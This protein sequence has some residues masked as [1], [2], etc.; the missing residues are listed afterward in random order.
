MKNELVHNIEGKTAVKIAQSVEQGV[1]CGALA[2]GA[3]LPTVRGLAES[4]G[5]SP[6]TAAAA[7]RILRERG[8]VFT[9][10]RRGTRVSTRLT[11][12]PA[13]PMAIPEG[14]RDL[15]TGNPDPKLLPDLRPA[16]R[17]MDATPHLYGGS[18]NDPRL[19]AWVQKDFQER[20][21]RKGEVVFVNGAMDG[22]ERVF[23]ETLKAGDRVAVEDPSF[24]NVL[25]LLATRGLV[26]VPVPVDEEGLVPEGLA[27]AC[28]TGI[29]AMVVAPRVQ[30]PT[31]ATLS[32]RRGEALRRVLREHP[33]V[34]LI[35]DDHAAL[36]CD[37]PLQPLHVQARRWV[38][39]CSF[40]KG[41]G[42]DLRL[43]AMTGDE[44][45]IRRVQER[46]VVGERWVSHLLQRLAAELLTDPNVR[47]SF[48]K[49]AEIYS[50]RRQ[51]L[52]DSLAGHGIR[53]PSRS[54]YNV[55]IPVED[56]GAVVRGLFERGWGVAPGERFRVRSGP[57]I[58]VTSAS[59]SEAD[60]RRLAAD[61]ADVIAGQPAALVVV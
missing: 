7:F 56:E 20:G 5:I 54:G 34:L 21:I 14:V 47:R 15:C 9:D 18:P 23:S 36:T 10:G 41:I 39:I 58:R 3:L 24:G 55:W 53:T 32:V 22:M 46:M 33:D 48:Q 42:P 31:G 25:D 2:A 50:R 40:S 26:V 6:A 1:R 57:A 60:S 37:V 28:R 4:C 43:A 17:R 35:E 45:T 29:S 38:H 52:V 59:L 13:R 61:L 44:S 11:T 49:T 16:L 12:R 51:A 8:V 30:N 19:V 27:K